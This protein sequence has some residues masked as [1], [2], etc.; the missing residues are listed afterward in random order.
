M[1]IVMTASLCGEQRLGSLSGIST[2]KRLLAGMIPTFVNPHG[3]FRDKLKANH[4]MYLDRE[5]EI[6][7]PPL[8]YKLLDRGC[9]FRALCPREVLLSYGSMAN[10][11]SMYCSPL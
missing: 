7:Y 11:V 2:Y 3:L 5:S 9:D 1:T 10:S 4:K 6:N 8:L